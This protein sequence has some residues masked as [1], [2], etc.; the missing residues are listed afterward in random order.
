MNEKRTT[1]RRSGMRM[2]LV[3]LALYAMAL[4]GLLWA[5]LSGEHEGVLVV[6]IAW[7]A[8]GWVPLCR[9]KVLGSQQALDLTV[10]GKRIGTLEGESSSSVPFLVQCSSRRK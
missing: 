3:I 8:L 2:L 9:I 1:K 4:V 7:L 5:A 10:F 6:C